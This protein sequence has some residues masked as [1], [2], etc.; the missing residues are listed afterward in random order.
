MEGWKQMVCL[1][2]NLFSKILKIKCTSCNAQTVLPVQTMKIVL[3]MSNV[4]FM[5]PN[6]LGYGRSIRT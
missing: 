1:Y 2:K 6:G 3:A 5:D 4:K